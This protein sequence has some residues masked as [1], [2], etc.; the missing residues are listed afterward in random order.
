MNNIVVMP[1]IIPLL[2]G[3]LLVF[4]RP[5]VKVQR[6]FSLVSIVATVVVSV[7]ILNLIQADG[8]L[9]LDFGGWLPPYGISFVADSFSMLLVLTTAIVTGIL[10]NLCVFV[11]WPSA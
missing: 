4:L 7:Y 1:M 2:T 6:V 3:I 8:I 10:L 9:R 5:Y 11:D